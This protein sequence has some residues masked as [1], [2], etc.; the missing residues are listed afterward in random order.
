[1]QMPSATSAAA[2]LA[3]VGRRLR[4]RLDRQP[5]DLQPRAVAARSARCPGRRRTG[6]PGTVSDV[7]AT[8]VASTTRRPRVR[9]EDA[10]LLGASTAARTAAG[11][12]CRGS[13]AVAA[14]PRCRGSRARRRGRRARRRGPR[15]AARRRRRRSRRSGR[16]RRPRRRRRA[17]GS[18]PR[19]GTCG[20]RPRRPA[21]RRSA[22][23]SARGSIVAE[24][25][26]SFR[27]G[28]RGQQPLEVAEQEVDVEAA[29]VRLVDD[30][31]VVAAQQP[32]A[33]DLGQ[34]DAVGHQL[35]AACPR[36]SWSVKR[37]V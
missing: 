15:A 35:D 13:R 34:Q 2:A 26:I 32:V 4:D 8:L 1:M 6:C 33:L 20:R 16:G 21:R 28:R 9:L 12:R 18:A 19:P 3:L 23:R 30:D 14:R 36:A 7:S 11:P 25:M 22:R 29:L 5:L 37:T 10:V 24:V 27:S 31:R 17:A